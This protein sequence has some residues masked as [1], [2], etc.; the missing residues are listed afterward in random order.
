M[1]RREGRAEVL[2]AQWLLH[3]P[4]AAGFLKASAGTG[5]GW[6]LRR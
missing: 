2:A 1:Y 6:G 5:F 4:A 3:A